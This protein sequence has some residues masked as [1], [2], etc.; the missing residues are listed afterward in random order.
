VSRG[1][2]QWPTDTSGGGHKPRPRPMACS[3][4]QSVRRRCL[5]KVRI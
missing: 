4:I 1:A 2:I 5:S 3:P